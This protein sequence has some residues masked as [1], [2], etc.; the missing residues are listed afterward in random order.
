MLFC[1][2]CKYQVPLLTRGA[3]QHQ[4]S[5][6]RVQIV[7][8]AKFTDTELTCENICFCNPDTAADILIFFFTR[9]SCSYRGYSTRELP[10]K[11]KQTMVRTHKWGFDPPP[12]LCSTASKRPSMTSTL[13]TVKTFR[14]PDGSVPDYWVLLSLAN[15]ESFL[16]LSFLPYTKFSSRL[17]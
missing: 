9:K 10:E 14:G 6:H 8:F 16:S 4:R 7:T 5:W 12:F 15:R 17:V 1:F 11:T 2:G 13:V 3:Y